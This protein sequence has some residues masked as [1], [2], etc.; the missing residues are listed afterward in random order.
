MKIFR[1]ARP[2]VPYHG[3]GRDLTPTEGLP[4]C[5]QAI[6]ALSAPKFDDVEQKMSS[7]TSGGTALS[8]TRRTE[9]P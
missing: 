8:H 9:R 5:L 7:V 1:V 6:Q 4:G 3:R 2:F